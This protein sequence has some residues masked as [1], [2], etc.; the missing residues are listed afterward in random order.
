MNDINGTV[1]PRLYVLEGYEMVGKTEFIDSY[2]QHAFKFRPSYEDLNLR[3]FIPGNSRSLL[4]VTVLDFLSQNPVLIN[5]DMVFDRGL[6]S[7]LLYAK[8][9]PQNGTNIEQDID[10]FLGMYRMMDTK[11][12]YLYHTDKEYARDMFESSKSRTTNDASFDPPTFDKYWDE[13]SRTHEWAIEILEKYF[14]S[15]GVSYT[16]IPTIQARDEQYV[17]TKLDLL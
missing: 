9:Y 15:S 8:L 2:L 10:R 11:V 4:G 13:F 6:L 16:M 12:V 1:H 14:A 7:G 5:R 17:K 3:E